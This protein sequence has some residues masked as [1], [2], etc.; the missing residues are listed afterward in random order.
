ML[1]PPMDFSQFSDCLDQAVEDC[2]EDKIGCGADYQNC[3]VAAGFDLHE[4][5]P[6][7]E[8]PYPEF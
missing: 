4:I 5:T 8:T 1:C 6:P 3:M 2:K 7:P